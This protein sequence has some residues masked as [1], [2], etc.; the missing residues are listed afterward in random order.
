MSYIDFIAS[1]RGRG[2]QQWIS[3][4]DGPSGP[5]LDHQAFTAH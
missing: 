5:H 1:L 4:I 3:H 2:Q